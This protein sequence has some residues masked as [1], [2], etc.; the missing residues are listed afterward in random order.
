MFHKVKSVTPLPNYMLLV[1]FA[2]GVAKQYDVKPLFES[3]GDFKAFQTIPGLFE[4][5]TAD[6]GGYGISWNDD[7][8]LA[9][10]E[11]WANGVQVDTPFD[12]LIAFGDATDLWGLNEST[13]RKAVA[14]QKLVEG[15]DVKKFG[16]QWVVTRDAMEREYGKPLEKPSE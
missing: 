10:D 15:I 8:D 14:Y 2:D 5:V 3:M 4:Q 13:L 7:L 1:H 16:K 6:P 11:L 9:C 12:N